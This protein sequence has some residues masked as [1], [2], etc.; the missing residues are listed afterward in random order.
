[1][2]RVLFHYAGP[3]GDGR[4]VSAKFPRCPFSPTD[5]VSAAPNCTKDYVLFVPQ[6]RQRINSERPPCRRI[7]GE[8]RGA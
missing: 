2:K 1:M 5:R 3:G 6:S 4:A 7:A 8:N